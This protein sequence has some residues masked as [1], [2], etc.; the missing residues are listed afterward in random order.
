MAYFM[1]ECFAAGIDDAAR[2]DS[3][4]KVPGIRSW[5]LGAR[6]T[7]PVPEPLRMGLDPAYGATPLPLYNSTI[8]VMSKRLYNAFLAAGV[9]NLDAYEA[10][11]IDPRSSQPLRPFVAVNVI[12]TISAADMKRSKIDPAV[13]DR[14]IS[15]D[16][17]SVVIDDKKA[18]GALFFR[19]AENIS[20]IV[21][22]EQVA[23]SIDTA[24]FPG[25][26]FVPSEQWKG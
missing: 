7:V 8:L 10:E 24:Q 2:I 18:R 20:A 21:V 19:L 1:L 13:P 6:F 16:F 26:T 23:R 22:H 5:K 11:L 14:M 9:A 3:W 25:L 4:P 17:E 15:T 12:G